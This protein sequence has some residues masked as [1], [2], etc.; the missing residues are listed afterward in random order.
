MFPEVRL[1]G[2]DP[3]GSH[4]VRCGDELPVQHE[5]GRAPPEG[6]CGSRAGSHGSTQVVGDAEVVGIH[7]QTRQ[8]AVEPVL[9]YEAGDL[10]RQK[11]CLG[12]LP[13]IGVQR[14]R[15]GKCADALEGVQ[16]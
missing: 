10:L 12:Q 4:L 16:P 5:H 14:G 13:E 8:R 6:D 9:A 15:D 7:A 11:A 3:G 2:R 1:D